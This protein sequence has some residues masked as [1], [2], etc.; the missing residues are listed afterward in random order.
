MNFVIKKI[1]NILILSALAFSCSNDDINSPDE[2]SSTQHSNVEFLRTPDER[3]ENLDGYDFEPN[4]VYVDDFEDGKLRM[5]YLDEGPENAPTIFLIHGNPTWSYQFRDVI[6]L[7]NEA[8]YRTIAI[9]LMGT[10]R[11]DKPVDLEYYTYDRHVKWVAQLFEQIDSDLQLGQVSI[12]GHD[13][14]TPIG[15]RL[16]H[17]YFP[18]RFDSFINANASLPDGTF[19]SPVHLNWREFVRDNPNVPVGNVISSQVNPALSQSEIDSYNAPYPDVNYKAAIR[20]FP[21]MVP[22]SPNRPEAIANNNAW[23]FMEGFHK[24]FMTIFGSVDS[25]VFDARIDFIDRIPGAYGQPH[26][27][28]EV[29]HYA[30][31]DKPIA[32][33]EQ[34]ITFLNDVYGNSTFNTVSYSDFSDGF[35]D[36]CNA[37]T[38]TF[39]N[40]SL[41]AIALQGNNGNNSSISQTSSMNIQNIEILKIAF[42]YISSEMIANDAFY[43]ELWNGSEWLTLCSF[44]YEEDFSNTVKDYGF[45]RIENDG[46]LFTNDAKIRV[47]NASN[48][49]DGKLFLLDIAIYTS[50]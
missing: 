21:E 35:Q 42:R 25:N 36:F 8:G 33:A 28:L 27:Q 20:S 40:P 26:P 46:N 29:T 11:S 32:V 39:Y 34:A 7:F 13:Y 30:P 15:I 37:R 5:H 31:E 1:S 43:I 24:P 6:R 47:R 23:Q 49:S 9:D 22:D 50:D 44:E 18:S 45:A 48:N 12:F 4:Y 17:E 2:G 16:M 41:E 38:H 14:G 10:G 3:F 19:I